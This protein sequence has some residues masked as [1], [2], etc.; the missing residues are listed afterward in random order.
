MSSAPVNRC[1]FLPQMNGS[2]KAVELN[3]MLTRRENPFFQ[4]SGRKKTCPGLLTGQKV[5]GCQLVIAVVC[6]NGLGCRHANLFPRGFGGDAAGNCPAPVVKPS[7]NSRS[8]H[9]LL[10][11]QEAIAEQRGK[12]MVLQDA[13]L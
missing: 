5:L 11:L 10:L 2:S 8:W 3:Q 4:G 1:D 9:G 6:V 13:F 7:L 12:G